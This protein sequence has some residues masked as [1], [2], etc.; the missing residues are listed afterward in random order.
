[1]STTRTE[2]RI[3]VTAVPFRLDLTVSALRRLSTNVVDLITVDAE[4]LRVFGGTGEPVLARISQVRADELVVRIEGGDARDHVRVLAVARR[5]L[6]TDRDVSQFDRAARRVPWLRD[7]VV[8]MRGVK[9]P[10]YPTLWEACVNAVLFQQVSLVSASSISRRLILALGHRV[11]SGSIALYSFPDV[12]RLRL[13]DDGVLRAAG[14]SSSKL[15]T[16]RRIADALESGALDEATLEALPSP[17]AAALLRGIKG[18]GPWTATLILLRGLGRLDVFPMNDSSVLRNLAFV[19]GTARLD[20]DELLVELGAQRG[21]LYYY[22][23]L[24][25]L[26]TRGDVGRASSVATV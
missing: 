24:A 10:R 3:E 22:L 26:E 20:I 19:A 11:E 6:G 16:L 21:M 13:A 7:L 15:A 2:Y 14:V 18:I 1:M 9:P 12:E 4:Y 23:L 25:R 8:R 17:D 5:I